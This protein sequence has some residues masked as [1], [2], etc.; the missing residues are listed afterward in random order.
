MNEERKQKLRVRYLKLT[1]EY[2][3]VSAAYDCESD[4]AEYLSQKLSKLGR[5]IRNIEFE[6]RKAIQAEKVACPGCSV[7]Q[8]PET[9]EK[10]HEDGCKFVLGVRKGV[11]AIH[12]G[13]VTPWS[14]V[15]KSLDDVG[16]VPNG[17][18]HSAWENEGG[19]PIRGY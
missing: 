17:E 14:D 15:E 13:H 18:A 16:N 19:A 1:R 8:G 5:E 2:R 7:M 6:V 12:S 4:V 10:A 3:H 11:E 9:P